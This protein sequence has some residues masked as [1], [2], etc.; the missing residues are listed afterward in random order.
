M[1]RVYSREQNPTKSLLVHPQVSNI[2][3]GSN[4]CPLDNHPGLHVLVEA[5][6]RHAHDNIIT[7]TVK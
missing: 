7:I 1:S 5:S 4:K 6:L 2:N 3:R